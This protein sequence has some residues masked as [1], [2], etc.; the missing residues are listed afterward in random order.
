[1]KF[2]LSLIGIL[3]LLIGTVIY[4][5]ST[6]DVVPSFSDENETQEEHNITDPK[7]VER[8][9]QNEYFESKWEDVKSQI[10]NSI[11]VYIELDKAKDGNFF[12][13]K[14]ASLREELYMVFDE[15]VQDL[16]DERIQ[17][18]EKEIQEA[19]ENIQE[20]LLTIQEYEEAMKEAP[21]ESYISTTVE[22][23]KEKI[24]EL[25]KEIEIEK[26]S[27]ERIYKNI[28]AYFFVLG[29]EL[30]YKKLE[31]L[32]KRIDFEYMIDAALVMKMLQKIMVKIKKDAMVN[33]F[34]YDKTLYYHN[35][36]RILFEFIIYQQN[37]Y[38]QKIDNNYIPKLNAL[39]EENTVTYEDSAK[40][41]SREKD[42]TKKAIYKDNMQVLKLFRQAM[43][44]Y[45]QDL[46]DQR[47]RLL[48]VRYMS[49]RHLK[50][51]QNRYKTSK[52]SLES[53][54]P[55]RDMKQEFSKITH[56][57]FDNIEITFKS[58]ELKRKY[59]K[60]TQKLRE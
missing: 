26:E 6:K 17:N 54:K 8:K 46:I 49:A 58:E 33:K 47:K 50:L 5:A 60:V 30:P 27:I 40:S 24:K 34:E 15:I 2:L 7:K 45:K 28:H 9:F 57:Y 4:I 3:L 38:I 29:I 13:D 18:Y 19:Q 12:W 41:M 20:D 51:T 35:I 36:N 31:M 56:H 10:D 14:K 1:M 55:K 59:I 11:E 43:E 22:G 44:V 48:Q 32:R 39:L 42:P 23:Y 21:K 16:R 53:L 37:R 25:E 52:L